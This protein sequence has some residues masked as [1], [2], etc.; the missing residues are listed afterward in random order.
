[1]RPEARTNRL[2]KFARCALAAGLLAAVALAR[3]PRGGAEDKPS[4]EKASRAAAKNAG[5]VEVRLT[6]NSTLKLTLRDERIEVETRYGKLLIPVAEVR[7]VEFA[8]RV[9][10]DVAKRVEAAVANL[11]SPQFRL[12]EAA[13]AELIALRERA[14]P[15]LLRAAKHGDAETARR[16]EELLAH[17][18]ETVPGDQLAIRAHDVIQTDEMK[19]VGRITAAALPVNTVAFGEQ[20][21]KLADVRS[22]R[23]LA[24]PEPAPE[25]VAILP[26]PGNLVTLQGQIGKTFAFTVTGAVNGSVWGTDIYTSDS[27]LAAAAVHAGVL[28][29][30]QTGVVRVTVIAPLPAFQGS[31]RNGVTSMPYGPFPG[32]YRVVR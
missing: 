16:A 31:A 18:R 26:D 24:V 20:S 14:Y 29:P 32:A 6:D 13:S 19:V 17:L 12:R 23:S 27:T 11:G 15:G 3:P 5:A 10:D 8:T 1:M 30:G 4:D 28:Q 21:L 25:A 7:Q 22:L 2:W 9:A